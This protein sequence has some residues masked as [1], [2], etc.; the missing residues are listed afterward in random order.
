[1]VWSD[2]EFQAPLA[3]V[4]LTVYRDLG[5][6]MTTRQA[7]YIEKRGQFVFLVVDLLPCVAVIHLLGSV[8]DFLIKELLRFL[9]PSSPFQGRD[10]L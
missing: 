10:F 6:L 1:M 9:T 5:V 8:F 7:P 2:Q 3:N 4:S